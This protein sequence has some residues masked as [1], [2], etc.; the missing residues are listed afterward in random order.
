MIS[1]ESE[2][3]VYMK[4]KSV[5]YMYGAGK[6]AER[7]LYYFEKKGIVIKGIIVSERTDNPKV[8][9][10]IPVISM[11]ELEKFSIES[12]CIDII[13][14]MTGGMKKWLPLFCKMPDFKSVF[15]FSDELLRQMEISEL[16][17]RFEDAQD[18]YIMDMDYPRTE[19]S[20]GMLIEKET[21]IAIMRFLRYSG[22]VSVNEFVQSATREAFEDEFGLLTVIPKVEQSGFSDKILGK[23]KAEIY[24]IISHLDKSVVQENQTEGYNYLQ[25]GAVLTTI[26][27]SVL[28]D[29]VGD[30]ISERNKDYCECTGLYWIWKNT[31]GQEYVGLCHYRRRLMLNDESLRYIKENDVDLVVAHPQYEKED[32]KTFFKQWILDMDWKLLKKEIIFYDQSYALYFERYE[33]GHFYFPCNIMFWKRKWFDCYCEFAFTVAEKIYGFYKGKG[34]FREDRYMGYLFEQ[35]LSLFIMRHYGEMYVVCSQIEWLGQER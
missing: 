2:L 24:V 35:L 18:N 25:A 17:Y 3:L 27:K 26:R 7:Y 30:N 16:K 15:F 21:G 34:I 13:V 5:L 19:P 31:S 29:D 1:T 9:H 8:F 12:N 32:I 11:D 22:S 20:Q 6:R 14:T 4:D 10:G 28:R 33:A 23:G